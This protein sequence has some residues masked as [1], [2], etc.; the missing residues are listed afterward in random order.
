VLLPVTRLVPFTVKTA[1][2]VP[3]APLNAAVPSAG[4]PEA[5]FTAENVTVPVGETAPLAALTVTVRTVDALDVIAAGLAPKVA[6]LARSGAVS[7]TVTGGETEAAK[8]VLP[9]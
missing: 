8:L 3:P 9:A 7:V 4:E 1:V 2:A 6:L 5:G